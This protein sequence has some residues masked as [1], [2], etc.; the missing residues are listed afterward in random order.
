[1]EHVLVME[2]MWK[3][4]KKSF[5]GIGLGLAKFFREGAQSGVATSEDPSRFQSG[6]QGCGE[7]CVA[8]IGEGEEAA[9]N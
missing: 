1:M 2:F 6:D 3:L 9:S 7:S 5:D 4:G 8:L